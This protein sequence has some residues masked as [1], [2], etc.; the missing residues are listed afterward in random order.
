MR[1]IA[2]IAATAGQQQHGVGLGEPRL[3]AEQ[4]RARHHQRSGNAGAAAQRRQ[5]PPNRSAGRR[6]S[7]R[8]ATAGDRA[9][10]SCAPAARRAPHRPSPRP[11]AASRFRPASCS[12]PRPENGCRHTRCRFQHLLGGLREAGLVA[13]DRRNLEE[14]RKERDE[15]EC[16]E[17]SRRAPV[18]CHGIVER[19]S[20]ASRRS[21]RTS[22]PD[23][24]VV[25]TCL[26]PLIS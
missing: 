18:R 17:Q 6:L 7:H 16:H 15:R 26:K 10:W 23:W 13:V 22:V 3:D 2:P 5:A 8:R 20:Q 12:G 1:A 24:Y 21:K 25:L 14:A 11:P 9:R 4:D 19:G